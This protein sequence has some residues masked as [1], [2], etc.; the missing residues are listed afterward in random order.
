[1]GGGATILKAEKNAPTQKFMIESLDQRGQK[2]RARNDM[3]EPLLASFAKRAP[4]YV[5]ERIRKSS[6][7]G[8]GI[9]EG[10]NN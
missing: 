8:P 7:S 4:M 10:P 5:G 1:M 6:A 9:S 3:G 2:S